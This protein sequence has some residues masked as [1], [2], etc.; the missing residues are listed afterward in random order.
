MIEKTTAFKCGNDI[1][2]T[3]REAQANS[4]AMILLQELKRQELAGGIIASAESN[5]TKLPDLAAALADAI[6]TE[7][8]QILDILTTT[9]SSKPSARKIH[10]GS[11]K[12]TPKAQPAAT[13]P[14]G[15][16]L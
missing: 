5:E 6:L 16:P 4:I 13:V 3:L 15:G 7:K 14:A 10:G 2:S 9:E 12:R 1:Y 8:D 11:K